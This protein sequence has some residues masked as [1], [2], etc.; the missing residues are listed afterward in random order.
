VLL[1]GVSGVVVWRGR[2]ERPWLVGWLWYLATLL[3]VIGLV[4]VGGQSLAD[5]YTYVPLIGV[6]IM[7][8]WGL[9]KRMFERRIGRMAAAVLA[10]GVLCVCVVLSSL[11][12]RYWRNS[13]TL[14]RHALK[15]TTGNAQ[16]HNNL[17]NTLAD[18][19]KPA[20]AV[21]EYRAALRIRPDFPEACN[22]LGAVLAAQGK[23]AEAVVEYTAALQVSPHYA[24]A[25]YN[26]A[27]VLATE[28]KLA[29]AIT[30]YQTVLQLIPKFAEAHNN[31]ANALAAQGK[32][33]EA[34]AEYE[35]ALRL[36]P[37]FAEARYNLGGV[38]VAQGQTQEASAQY[39]EVLRYRPDWPPALSRLAWL[40]A[41]HKDPGVRNG[42]EAV[43]LAE[44]L[45]QITGQQQ[46]GALDVLAAAYAEAGRFNDAVG[47]AQKAVALATA[48]QPDLIR[49]IGERLKSY[50]AERPYHE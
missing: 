43:R 42:A 15:V 17:G 30:E 33:V 6:F 1:A 27:N 20:E 7:V 9:P 8:A 23:L 26:L 19:G 18:Q 47:A 12:V 32:L 31:L 38:L 28:G 49:P 14:F 35:A 39:R 34:V 36:K 24:Q 4:Q 22:N 40:L 11:Q 2:R 41:T 37:D 10:A 16:A 29:E 48:A 21:I 13:E 25:H 46:A 44:R 45:C 5:R 50:Q 3:P